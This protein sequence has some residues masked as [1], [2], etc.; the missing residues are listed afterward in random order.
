[1]SSLQYQNVFFIFLYCINIVVPRN[2]LATID[3]LGSLAVVPH[4]FHDKWNFFF[5]AISQNYEIRE[6][7]HKNSLIREM[8]DSYIHLCIRGGSFLSPDTRSEGF[9][10][11]LNFFPE[12]L[13][14]MKIFQ[15]IV[16]GMKICRKIVRGMKIFREIVRGMKFFNA[17]L[18]PLVKKNKGYE[19]FK[20]I[21]HF[22]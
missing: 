21:S 16:R 20:G 8:N 22:P 3:R 4:K 18:F 6:I 17:F 7:Y 10:R 9:L 14:G 15:K 19:N 5:R 12:N 11:G 13:R 1:M 2:D